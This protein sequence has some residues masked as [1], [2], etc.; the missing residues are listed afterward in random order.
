MA[1]K[2]PNKVKEDLAIAIM[3]LET[4]FSEASDKGKDFPARCGAVREIAARTLLR[5]GRPEAMKKWGQQL[6]LQLPRDLQDPVN[7]D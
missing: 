3:R 1:T 5:L 4:I 6:S 7:W 2:K